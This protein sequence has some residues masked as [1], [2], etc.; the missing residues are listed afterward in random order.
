MPAKNDVVPQGDEISL[1]PG[2]CLLDVA[3]A[4]ESLRYSGFKRRIRPGF[5]T[6]K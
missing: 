1:V 4:Q 2:C 3:Q 5:S 6:S